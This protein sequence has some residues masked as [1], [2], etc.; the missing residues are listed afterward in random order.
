MKR[1]PR[2]SKKGTRYFHDTDRHSY[3]DSQ[4]GMIGAYG[5]I[6]TLKIQKNINQMDTGDPN[7]GL[8]QSMGEKRGSSLGIPIEFHT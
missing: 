1:D 5:I 7:K 6:G 3:S 4:K 8:V 2:G